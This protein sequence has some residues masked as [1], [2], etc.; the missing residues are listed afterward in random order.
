MKN[1]LCFFLMIGLFTWAACRDDKGYPQAVRDNFLNA[2][3]KDDSVKRVLCSCL[4]DKI[5]TNYTFKEYKALEAEIQAGKTNE[6]FNTF[7]TSAAD[8]CR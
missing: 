2:C 3:A 8:A 6:A 4:L 7:M 5:E 1:L